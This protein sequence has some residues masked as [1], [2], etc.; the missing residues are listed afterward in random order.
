MTVKVRIPTAL[1]A[2]TGQQ[3]AVEVSGGTVAEAVSD[4]LARHES[5]R[6]HLLDEGG[7]LRSF[8]NLYVNQTDVR[9]LQNQETPLKAG[10][11]LLIV[12]SVAG[13]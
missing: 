8:V 2:Y 1:R 12:P 9:A 11:T 4:L 5:L 10:D 6:P 13:G 3:A 7:Q